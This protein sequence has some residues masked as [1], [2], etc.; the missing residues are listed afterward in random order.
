MGMLRKLT[1][2][3]KKPET[4]GTSANSMMPPVKKPRMIP[5][6]MTTSVAIATVMVCPSRQTA[7]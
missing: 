2:A 6:A 7:R 4:I 3:S 5:A 1:L